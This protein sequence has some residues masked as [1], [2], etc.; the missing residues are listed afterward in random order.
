MRVYGRFELPPDKAELHRRAVRLEWWTIVFFLVAILLLAVTLGQ[1]QAMKAAW[2]E[3]MLGLVPPAAFLV[4]ARFRNRRPTERFPYAYHRSVSVA[5]LAGSVAL[6]SLG[7]YVVYDSVMR[8]I[9]KERPPIGLVELFGQRFWLG[10]LMI[11]VLLATMVPAILL[12]RVKQRIARELHDKVLFADAEMN[13]ADWLTAGAAVLGILGIG[14]G[15]WWADAVAALI[16]GAD[17]VRDG[18]RTTRAAVADLMDEAP[19][20]VD[21]S[22]P[23]P[24]PR[25]LLAAVLDHDWVADAWLRL[26]EEGHVF[27]GELLVV[28]VADT[29][30]LTERV[31]ELERFARAFNWRVHDLVVAPV[32]AIE[33]ADGAR[34]PTPDVMTR[35]P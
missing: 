9:A 31:E 23:H 19:S 11:V 18:V 34:P 16:I 30:R 35:R 21:G 33:T 25:E 29:D 14:A 6:L 17:I 22:G 20:L 10:W 1:S 32:T 5:F 7:G 27:V 13:R 4:A 26:R 3:D 8:L 2:I 28:P 24:L 12:G 15:L